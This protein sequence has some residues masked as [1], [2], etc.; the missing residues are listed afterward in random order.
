MKSLMLA[1]LGEDRSTISRHFPSDVSLGLHPTSKHT[2]IS[3]DLEPC[4]EDRS[5]PPLSGLEMIDC[6][7]CDGA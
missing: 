4:I 3:N 1:P 6:R 5:E 2:Q 7:T